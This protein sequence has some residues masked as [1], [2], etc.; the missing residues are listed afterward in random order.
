ML[1]SFLCFVLLVSVSGVTPVPDRT[2]SGFY[3]S[4]DTEFSGGIISVKL[5][6]MKDPA[7]KKA[8]WEKQKELRLQGKREF[9]IAELHFEKPKNW[10]YKLPPWT[11]AKVQLDM[12]FGSS[13]G[14]TAYPEMLFAVTP[15]E[16]NVTWGGQVELMNQIYDYLSK[17][18]NVKVF[19]WLTEPYAPRLDIKADGWILDAY[20]IHGEKFFRHLQK[21]ILYGKPVI[22]IVWAAEPFGNYYRIDGIKG[23]F[24]DASEQIDYCAELNLPVILFAVSGKLGSVNVW[25]HSKDFPFPELRDFFYK[26]LD[27]IKNGKFALPLHPL[28]AVKII[29][30]RQGNY[31][32][33]TVFDNFNFVDLCRIQN[34]D[35]MQL[36][37]DGLSAVNTAGQ[38]EWLWESSEPVTSATLKIKAKGNLHV[39]VSIDGK[40]QDTG[41]GKDL[42]FKGFCRLE[43]ALLPEVGALLQS[44]S[45]NAA[46]PFVKEPVTTWTGRHKEYFDDNGFMRCW[47]YEDSPQLSVGAYGIGIYPKESRS[48]RWEASRHFKSDKPLAGVRLKVACHAD[49]KSHS[50]SVR[51]GISMDAKNIQWSAD[52]ADLKAAENNSMLDIP[53]RFPEPVHDFYVHIILQANSGKTNNVVTA[54]IQNIE[55]EGIDQ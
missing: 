2:V 26:K 8:F 52:T 46:V 38:L 17:T 32:F 33:E 40:V 9:Y 13:D 15:S 35:A 5:A 47:E 10:K 16:E 27:E 42:T 28:D 39:Q 36:S 21:F 30:D 20:S 19:Q 23:V 48:F 14:V 1:Y 4:P 6:N 18:Y 25:I 51:A 45:L 53:V 24:R 31:S 43:L 34:V 11:E 22:P 55:I 41:D 50:S 7:V 3:G 29:P 54:S 12:F 37:R 49:A 44:L